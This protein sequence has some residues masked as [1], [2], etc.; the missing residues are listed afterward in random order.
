MFRQAR[1]TLMQPAT[2]FWHDAIGAVALFVILFAGLHLPLL[3]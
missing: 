1:K 3:S 2:Q